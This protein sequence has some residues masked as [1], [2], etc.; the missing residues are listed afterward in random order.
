MEA[1][2][3]T[4]REDLSKKDTRI[5]EL[6][7]KVA[8]LEPFKAEAEQLK[9]DKAAAEL[10]AKQQ[11]LTSFAE[12]QG[13][14]VKETAIAEAIQKADYAALVA[15]A[16]KQPKSAAKPTMASYALNGGLATKGDYDDLLAKA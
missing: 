2:L 3:A 10:A 13:L 9:Q 15:A 4:C 6:E 11:E 5:A 8:E 12:T 16:V 14:D 7:A 1:E